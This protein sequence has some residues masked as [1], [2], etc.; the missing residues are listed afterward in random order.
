MSFSNVHSDCCCRRLHIDPVVMAFRDDLSHIYI[1]I[2]I[3]ITIFMGTVVLR[4]ISYTH[5]EL[6][7]LIDVTG[8]S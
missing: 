8:A 1:Y 7:A 2:Y 4:I 5:D 6:L 3:Y